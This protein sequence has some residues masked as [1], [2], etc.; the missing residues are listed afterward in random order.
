MADDEALRVRWKII[1]FIPGCDKIKPAKK[2]RKIKLG[3]NK[4]KVKA[5]KK[6][7]KARLR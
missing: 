5:K 2:H 4:L 7:R 1:P 3:R 6:L